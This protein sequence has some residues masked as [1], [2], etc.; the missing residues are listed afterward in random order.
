MSDNDMTR[1][2]VEPVGLDKNPQVNQLLE[3][4]GLGR[5]EDAEVTSYR[6]RN[7]NWAG[8]TTSGRS[9]FVKQILGESGDIQKRIHHLAAFAA[10]IQTQPPKHFATPQLLGYDLN[11]RIV[12]HEHLADTV[13]GSELAADE[14]FTE[15][16]ATRCGRAFAELHTIPVEPY[17]ADSG[18]SPF[19]PKDDL[20]AIPGSGYANLSAGA[21]EAWA[22][23]HSDTAVAEAISDLADEARRYR[24]PVHADLRIDQIMVDSQDEMYVIDWEEFRL[25]DPAR[26][27]GA[28]AGEWLFKA[29]NNIPSQISKHH[30][31]QAEYQATDQEIVENG[32]AELDRLRPLIAAFWVGY[33]TANPAA[34]EELAV[35]SVRWAGW[36]MFDRM[37]A[38]ADQSG[39]LPAASRAAAGIGR[40]ALL[41]PEQFTTTLG[42]DAA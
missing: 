26:D 31:E 34:G 23:L 42:L 41:F 15:E 17:Q 28:F 39:R 1:I 24:S 30:S 6:G 35:R 3:G 14:K 33:T 25:S 40:N 38:I 29:I 2:R 32:T 37:L 36:H 8:V 13:S 20:K 27:I 18:A 12:V 21:I 5:L 4:L 10:L 16:L 19:P 9:V 22:L 11:H 7:D